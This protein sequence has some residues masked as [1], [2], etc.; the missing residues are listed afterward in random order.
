MHLESHPFYPCTTEEKEEIRK[1]AGIKD[2]V[3]QED[4]DAI[5]DWFYKEPHLADAVIG[6]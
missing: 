6:K 4:I 1:E 5:L 2:S 3:L